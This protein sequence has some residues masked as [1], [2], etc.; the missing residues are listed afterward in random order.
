MS[1]PKPYYE[2]PGITI[3]CGDCRTILPELPQFDLVLTD[4]PYGIQIN[5]GTWGIA[6]HP[7]YQE[8]DAATI[9]DLPSILNKG[10]IQVC[11]GGNYYPLPPSRCWLSWFKPDAVPTMANFELAWTNRDQNSKQISCSIAST[12]AERIGHPTQKPVRVMLWCIEQ[13]RCPDGGGNPRPLHGK[14]HH[15]GRGKAPWPSRRRH[16]NIPEVLRDR[17]EPTPS[18]RLDNGMN[19]GKLS[20]A[21]TT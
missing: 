16:R 5:G 15:T 1:L 14:R 13:S 19:V 21:Q 12:N 7:E 18:G 6:D 2:E 17:G 9:P 3:Y 8:W 11:W 20:L 10:K 4:P